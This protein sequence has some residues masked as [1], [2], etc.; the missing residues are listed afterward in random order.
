MGRLKIEQEDGT[1]RRVAYLDEVQDIADDTDDSIN[2]IENI[3][4]RLDSA[5]PYRLTDLQ[6][7][8]IYRFGFQLSEEGN[9]QLI[10]EEVEDV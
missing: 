3:F 6:N 4:T 7:D 5:M 2:D 8:K 1:V 9:P 10:F